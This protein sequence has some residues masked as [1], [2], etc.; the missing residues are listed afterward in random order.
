L[1]GRRWGTAAGA[2][3][4]RAFCMSLPE[5]NISHFGSSLSYEPIASLNCLSVEV[6]RLACDQL[7]NF[8]GK[9]L[10]FGGLELR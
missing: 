6:E 5:D 9:Y 7:R 3:G 1:I 8:D 2:N 4:D 10:C